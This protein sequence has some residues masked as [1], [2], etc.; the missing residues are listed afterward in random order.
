VLQHKETDH[1]STSVS[2]ERPLINANPL[3][4]QPVSPKKNVAINSVLN[5]LP[6][7]E[8]NAQNSNSWTHDSTVI[9][10]TEQNVKQ[11]RQIDTW[12]SSSATQSDDEDTGIYRTKQ[13]ST[14]FHQAHSSL[15]GTTMF[16]TTPINQHLN[17]SKSDDDDSIEAAIQNLN[18]Q[19]VNSGIQSLVNKQIGEGYK[20]TP[21]A[22]S[23]RSEESSWTTSSVTANKESVTKGVSSLIHQQ[24]LLSKKSSV[25]TW[26]DSRPLSADLQ[27]TIT[28]PK[29][30]TSSS[31][32]DDNN[33]KSSTIVKSP[34]TSGVSSN[35]VQTNIRTS[36]FTEPKTTG[37]EN[38]AKIMGTIGHSSTSTQIQ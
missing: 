25:S 11:A 12:D 13:A 31:S 24:P 37:V 21:S 15:N 32:D 23:P 7:P 33:N 38:L 22:Q 1:T 26:D 4:G 36:G 19:K 10:K 34:L 9:H 35:V 6:R 8:I 2:L 18:T 16:T 28:K 14:N 27:R 17:D 29:V 20:V 3:M 5:A 30:E